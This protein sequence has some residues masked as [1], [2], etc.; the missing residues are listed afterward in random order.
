MPVRTSPVPAVARTGDPVTLT[1][2]RPSGSAITVRLPFRRVTAPAWLAEHR[3]CAGRS[4]S[5]SRASHR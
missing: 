4:A 5:R 3:A 2:S 1:K